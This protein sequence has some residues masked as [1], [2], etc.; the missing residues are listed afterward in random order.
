MILS[1]SRRTDI[2]TYYS[3]WFFN[4]IRDGYAL[5]RNPM[6]YHQ[7]SKI[8]ITPDVVD[9]IVFW[10]KNPIPMLPRLGELSEYT[11]Y[12][13]FT[14]NSYADDIEPSIPLKSKY[15][16]PAF[17]KLSDRIG[18]ERVIW[19]YDP[20]LLN[21]KYSIGYHLKYFANLAKLL[22][23]YTKKCTFS[24]IDFY[25]NTQNNV[26]GLE[27]ITLT[28]EHKLAIAKGLSEI[29][30]S[31]GLSIDT[32]AEDIDLD[33]F[34]ITHARCV[35]DRLLGKLLG[36][37]LKVEKDKNQRFS[38]GCVASVDI[39]MYNTCRNGCKYCY[40]NYSPKSVATNS[41]KHSPTSPV[42]CGEITDEDTITERP[43]KSCAVCSQQKIFEAE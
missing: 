26:K 9:G 2:P 14:L 19:R 12:F 16:I 36:R 24:F 30:H 21:D 38:C 7:L 4:R 13:Q 40:A 20:I 31:Y 25:R 39:G 32:C 15:I 5:V 34:G 33:Q 6:N 43:V 41:H 22:H 27:L 29:A 3:E 11:Y 1:A 35:D 37:T 10:T 23:P 17:Q 8:K 18:P 42:I 28:E